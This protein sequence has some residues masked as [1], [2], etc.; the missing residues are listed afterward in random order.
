[1]TGLVGLQHE[2]NP[3]STIEKTLFLID[4][5]LQHMHKTT[6]FISFTALLILVVLR[7]VKTAFKKY[8]WIY[9][10]PEV[11]IVVVMSTGESLSWCVLLRNEDLIGMLCVVL[12][13]QFRWDDDGVDILGS[14]PINTGKNLVRFPL[15]H[16]TVKYLGRTTSTAV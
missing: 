12:C 6:T 13:D 2:L 14:V 10:L 8:V 7:N 5:V 4:N 16:K 9:R 1:M 3:Q 15:H 11:L